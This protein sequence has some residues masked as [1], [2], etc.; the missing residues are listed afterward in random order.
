MDSVDGRQFFQRTFRHQ[1]NFPL[2][3]QDPGKK[4]PRSFSSPFFT[5]KLYILLTQ[6]RHRRWQF[7][8]LK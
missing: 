2:S 3:I 6:P 1:R 8:N 7:V 4:K 5:A